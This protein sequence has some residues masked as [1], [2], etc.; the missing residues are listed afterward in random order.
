MFKTCSTRDSRKT[1]KKHKARR[2][3][4]E[5]VRFHCTINPDNEIERISHV[6]SRGL[7]KLIF[8]LT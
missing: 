6:I 1:F 3:D 5:L 7:V 2:C 8:Y 4:E